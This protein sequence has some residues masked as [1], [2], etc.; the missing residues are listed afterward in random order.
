MV[1]L[2]EAPNPSPWEDVLHR[3]ANDNLAQQI[4]VHGLAAPLTRMRSRRSRRW[5]RRG[6]PSSRLQAITAQIPGRL[7]F[8]R[9]ARTLRLSAVQYLPHPV[10]GD[11]GSRRQPGPTAAGCTY[12]SIPPWQQGVRLANNQGSTTKRNIPDVSLTAENVYE[13]ADGQDYFYPGTSIAAPLWAGFA[14]LVNQQAA[15]NGEPSIGFVNPAIYA[16]G[17]GPN[18]ASCFHDITTGNNINR[19]S[20]N[21]FLAVSGYDLCTGSGYPEW[22]QPDQCPLTPT[23][24]GQLHRQ[25]DRRRGSAHRDLCRRID[26]Q[27]HQ[28]VLEF[29]RRRHHQ[30]NDAGHA[31]SLH[32]RGHL[33]GDGDRHR[34]RRIQHRHAGKLYHNLKPDQGIAIPSVAVSISN[35][36]ESVHGADER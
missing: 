9:T 32:H 25:P 16:I 17:T 24:D 6:S 7:V 21:R 23:T 34:L 29:R 12:Y 11:F 14:A 31:T 3:A 13:R 22:N 20:P 15:A 30:R 2:Y 35:C 33:C 1:I 5:P 10:L 8:R 26:R 19:S 18:Y 36:T 27:H 28:L 4:S